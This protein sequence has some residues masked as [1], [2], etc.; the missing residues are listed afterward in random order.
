MRPP[1]FST[2]QIVRLNAGTRA[3][4]EARCPCADGYGLR[5]DHAAIAVLLEGK[6]RSPEDGIPHDGDDTISGWGT[7][8]RLNTLLGTSLSETGAA[9][10]QLRL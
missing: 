9:F 7:R 10:T 4:A 8:L 6:S 3:V 1:A 5:A 2:F